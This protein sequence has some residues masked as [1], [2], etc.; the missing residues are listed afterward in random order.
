MDRF[1]AGGPGFAMFGT[2]SS[3]GRPSAGGQPP[4]I[5]AS[6]GSAASHQAPSQPANDVPPDPE[7]E[8]FENEKYAGLGATSQA[9]P[10]FAAAGNP[11]SFADL[12]GSQARPPAYDAASSAY[13]QSTSASSR[14]P[15]TPLS[16]IGLADHIQSEKNTLQQFDSDINPILD[17][18]ATSN[19]VLYQHLLA[20][21]SR[22]GTSRAPNND[23][24]MVEER[25]ARVHFKDSPGQHSSSSRRGKKWKNRMTHT[26]DD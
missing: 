9:A 3:T 24:G 26:F 12:Y 7:R 23:L 19:P 15:R 20:E 14:I 22:R 13:S 25:P 5:A 8:F 16:A 21:V 1:A 17:Q 2:G 18:L 4:A 11:Q 10:S 6:D